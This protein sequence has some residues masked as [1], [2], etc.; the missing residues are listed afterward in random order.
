MA[1]GGGEDLTG[2][3]TKRRYEILRRSQGGSRLHGKPIS[4]QVMDEG[5]DGHLFRF[6]T[7]PY[8]DKPEFIDVEKEER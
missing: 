5:A 3:G 2:S 8:F 4:P 6:V 1:G 7:I